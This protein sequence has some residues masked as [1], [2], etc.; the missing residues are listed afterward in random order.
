MYASKLVLNSNGWTSPTG[1]ASDGIE[2]G[3]L[4]KE[5]IDLNEF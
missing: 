1:L 2:N 5:N 3:W 4:K